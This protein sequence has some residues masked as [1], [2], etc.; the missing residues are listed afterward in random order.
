MDRLLFCLNGW[1]GYVLL[2]PEMLPTHPLTPTFAPQMSRN[3]LKFF[4][5]SQQS[6]IR[7]QS[8]LIWPEKHLFRFSLLPSFNNEKYNFLNW[9]LYSMTTLKS[10]PIR[11][12]LKTFFET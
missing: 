10:V 4:A 6:S 9:Q 1:N 3:S 2:L 7:P 8:L 5:Q 11:T 12:E